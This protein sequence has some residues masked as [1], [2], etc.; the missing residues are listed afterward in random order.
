MKKLVIATHNRNKFAEMKMALSGIG[1]E[2]IPAYDFPGIPEVIEDGHT[3]EENSLKKAVEVA[4]FT[5][6]TS[7]SDDTGLFVDALQGAPGIYAA[8]FAGINCTYK[9]NVDKLLK[10]LESVP[11]N[12][13]KAVF[14]TVVTIF[15]PSGKKDQ[16]SGEIEGV[17]TS[18][19]VGKDGFG[20][21]PI[22]LPTGHS[23]VFAEMTL[24]NKNK[25][26]HRGRALQKARTILYRGNGMVL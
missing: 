6:L 8:R 18:K 3:L 13:R 19:A 24:E 2:I 1:W 21:D 20:Y 5:G 9:D 25:I 7:L 17:I 23:K 11:I 22:F 12:R 15:H 16:V 26:S 14:R 4:E 10:L